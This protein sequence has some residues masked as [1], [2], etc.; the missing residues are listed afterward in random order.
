MTIFRLSD[1][2][3]LQSRLLPHMWFCVPP[4]CR[5]SSA[6]SLLICPRSWRQACLFGPLAGTSQSHHIDVFLMTD[7]CPLTVILNHVG[8]SM[9]CPS[10]VAKGRELHRFVLDVNATVPAHIHS[11]SHECEKQVAWFFFTVP[12]TYQCP[13]LL[14]YHVLPN[15]CTIL[16]EHNRSTK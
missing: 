11:R 4:L 7:S 13:S 9:L 15:V 5:G 16:Y 2:A 8:R 12:S 14:F 6:W 1:N 3:A 10:L